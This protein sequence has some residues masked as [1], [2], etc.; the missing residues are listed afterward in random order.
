MPAFCDRAFQ[1]RVEC[2]AREQGEKGWLVCITRAKSI[3]LDNGLK[4]S[5]AANRLR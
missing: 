3:F 5:D 1:A 2:V 4:A